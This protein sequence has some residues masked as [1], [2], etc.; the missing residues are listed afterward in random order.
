MAELDAAYLRELLAL[1][2]LADS[3]DIR[4]V[5]E[6][7]ST[8]DAVLLDFQGAPR[9]LFAESQSRGRGRRG[10]PWFT[11]PAGANLAFS[12]ALSPPLPIEHWSRLTHVAALAVCRALQAYPPV[13]PK[14]KWPNDIYLELKKVCGILL[15]SYPRRNCAVIGLGININ[16]TEEDFPPELRDIAT[17]LRLE[18][19][20]LVNR[21]ELACSVLFHLTE[22]L[23]SSAEGFA[24]IRE[25]LRE[26]SL[27]LGRPVRAV[28]AQGIL[29]GIAEDLG[30]EGEL[31]LRLP[32][33]ATLPLITAEEVRLDDE[34]K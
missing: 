25:E 10:A 27:L 4:T 6:V 34:V 31:I 18:T 5:E 21:H 14:I 23:G 19:K 32:T 11:G 1:R 8:N 29:R 13:N 15:E 20:T 26:N 17:S 16:G 30:T 2:G 33:G 3:W 28:Q 12:C 7:E 22:L 9:V 24:S